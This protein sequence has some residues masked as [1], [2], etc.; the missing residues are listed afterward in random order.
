[1]FRKVRPDL[2]ALFPALA[3][4]GF[5][6]VEIWGREE[7]FEQLH[8]LTQREGL[9][10][11]AMVGSGTPLN[12]QER[13]AEAEKTIR[14]SIDIAADHGVPN[15]I[16]FSGA[17]RE[18]QND[19]QGIEAIVAGFSR[20]AAH[21]EEKGITLLLELLNSKVDHPAY[22]AD[23]TSFGVE[24]CRRVNSSRVRLLYDIYHMQIM[25]GDVI[26][27]I[28]ENIEWIAH[29][30]TAGNPGRQDLDDD[31][32]LNYAA[33]AKAVSESGFSGFVG[34]EFVPKKDVLTAL[35]EAYALW[36]H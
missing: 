6:G 36:K 17:R 30:H 25:E 5:Q 10:I 7:N 22:Q 16:C 31:Q 9:Q 35:R 13:H 27:T 18:G 3:E 33:I 11:C 19:G 23:S 28:R 15:L 34:H 20:V 4:I 14:E 1:M 12:D 2:E 26:R 24:V 32:E 29:F 8:L 21:A